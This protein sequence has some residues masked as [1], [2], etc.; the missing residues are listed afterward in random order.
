MVRE[1]NKEKGR[2][3]KMNFLILCEDCGEDME[4]HSYVCDKC[5]QEVCYSCYLHHEKECF[6]G[7]E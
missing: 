6:E 3:T 1:N 5:G 2:G 4:G 7:D